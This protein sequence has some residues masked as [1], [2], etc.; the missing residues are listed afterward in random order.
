[1]TKT[2]L[3]AALGALAII[4]AA[5]CGGNVIVE[6]PGGAGGNGGS[7]TTPPDP[8]SYCEDA[9]SKADSYGCLEGGTVAEC[10]G[11]CES[12]FV[13]YE[14]CTKELA[15][16]YDCYIDGLGTSGCDSTVQCEE[17]S[18]AFGECLGG[19]TPSCGETACSAGP[20]DCYC[21]GEC[22]GELLEVICS[23][24]QGGVNCSCLANGAT[25]GTCIDSSLSCDAFDGCCSSYFFAQ[26]G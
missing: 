10:A 7:T 18:L 16:L 12:L 8:A 13:E 22:N 23:E 2:G 4:F 24:G 6:P 5:G 25:L 1:M 11:S 3:L 21:Q 19:V 20:S 15:A 17:E 26:E 14:E 9:C